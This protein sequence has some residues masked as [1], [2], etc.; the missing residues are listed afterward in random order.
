LLLCLP[1]LLGIISERALAKPPRS[2]NRPSLEESVRVRRVHMPVFIEPKGRKGRRSDICS[3]LDP[4]QVGV[5]EDGRAATVTNVEKTTAGLLHAILIDTS[6]SMEKWLQEVQAAAIDYVSDLQDGSEALVASFDDSLVLL[7]PPTSDKE[8]L[9]AA[10][11][12]TET[13]SKTALWDALRNLVGYLESIPGRKVL[14]LLTDGVDVSSLPGNAESRILDEILRAGNITIYPLG[15]DLPGEGRSGSV[16]LRARLAMLA[17]IAAGKLFDI[18]EMRQI[19]GAFREI[20]DRLARQYDVVYIPEPFG[21]GPKD[22]PDRSSQRWR[23][24]RIRAARGVPCHVLLAGPEKRLEARMAGGPARLRASSGGS[25]AKE[26]QETVPC[27]LPE[28]TRRPARRLGRLS[29]TVPVG[30][31]ESGEAESWV[32]ALASPSLLVGVATDLLMERGILYRWQPYWES[33]R[34]K[35]TIDRKPVFASRTFGIEVPSLADLMTVF[36]RP[37]SIAL[38]LLDRRRCLALPSRDYPH[39]RSPL[40]VNGQTFLSIRKLIGLALF[41]HYPEYR[42]WTIDKIRKERLPAVESALRE[43]REHGELDSDELARLRSVFLERMSRP[44]DDE[45]QRFLAEWLGDIRARDLAL[46]LERRIVNAL[47][48]A[49]EALSAEE[50][51]LIKR[52]EASWKDLSLWFPPA[53]HSRILV[54][55]VPVH[56]AERDAIGFFRI[57][58]PRPNKDGPPVDPVPRAPWAIWSTRWLLEKSDSARLLRGRVELGRIRYLDRE[59]A[60]RL[61]LGLPGSD[62][63]TLVLTAQM[64]LGTETPRC[65]SVDV[66]GRAPERLAEIAAQLIEALQRS[67]RT[68]GS[69]RL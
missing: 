63:H 32:D 55:L 62:G 6:P 1:P 38:H 3:H 54:P 46:A 67:G 40:L 39:S 20:R 57:I 16:I 28:E 18:R 47:L 35:A 52:V 45:P 11:R 50:G 34:Y 23:K 15:I 10:I 48:R 26:P 60:V 51:Q 4:S 37:E 65:V 7:S 9:I 2:E 24:V 61:G 33:G 17:D 41:E 22:D 13:G 36:S 42:A 14:L 21:R 19:D 31:P 8:R 30:T 25:A 53:T 64:P 44:D 49:P 59:R 29:A 5:S 56:E 69:P 66:D 43:L 27:L 68:C 12:K 58:L